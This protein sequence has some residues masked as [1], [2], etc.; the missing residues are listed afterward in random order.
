MTTSLAKPGSHF[1]RRK[2]TL[3]DWQLIYIEANAEW[4]KIFA[5]RKYLSKIIGYQLNISNV[6]GSI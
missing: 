4:E 3:V 6:I 2:L 1:D 5:H